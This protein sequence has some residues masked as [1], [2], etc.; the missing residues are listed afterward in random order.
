MAWVGVYIA[1]VLRGGVVGGRV[2]GARVVLAGVEGV[3]VAV[4]ILEGANELGAGVLVERV[5]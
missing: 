3:G 2:V 5:V 4:V 1:S